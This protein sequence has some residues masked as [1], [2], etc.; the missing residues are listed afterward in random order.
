MKFKYNGEGNHKCFELVA[1]KIMKTS[2]KLKKGQIVDV[3]EK[4]DRVIDALKVSGVFEQINQSKVV[5]KEEEKK[6]EDK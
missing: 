2:E 6:K 3:P 1:Y 5:K 4:Y